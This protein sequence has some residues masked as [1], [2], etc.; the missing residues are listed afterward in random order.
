MWQIHEESADL[1]LAQEMSELFDKEVNAQKG[2]LKNT[3]ANS[4]KIVKKCEKKKSNN[5]SKMFV[6]EEAFI[7]L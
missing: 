7:R 2:S 4:R 3:S 6:V 5:L 1:S